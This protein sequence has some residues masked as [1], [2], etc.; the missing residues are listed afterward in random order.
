METNTTASTFAAVSGRLSITSREAQVLHWLVGA[1]TNREIGIILGV[2][3]RTVGKHVENILAKLG[4]EN[5]TAAAMH[6]LEVLRG[7]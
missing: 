3:S 4:V 7:N 2:S 6:A 1:K 5:R